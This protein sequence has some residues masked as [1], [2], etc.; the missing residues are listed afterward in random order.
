[1]FILTKDGSNTLLNKEFNAHYHSLHGALEETKHVFIRSGLD[2]YLTKFSSLTDVA[3]FE[4]GFG[5]G[6]NAL[7]SC[8][9]ALEHK[10]HLNYTAI[11]KAPLI[12]F[13]SDGFI[14][15]MDDLRL[16][17]QIFKDIHFAAWGD[18]IAINPYFNIHKKHADIFNYEENEI[19]DI[20]FY[21]AFA[22]SVQPELWTTELMRR[23]HHSIKPNGLLITYCAQ[24]QFKRNLKDAGFIVESIPGPSGKREIT[25]GLKR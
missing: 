15:P 25:R 24:G 16:H 5:T 4:M 17:K 10:I 2:Y 8:I 20:I 18:S 21:D 19:N 13:D 23:L 11:E 7:M 1:M 6:L 12:N 9:Y 22:P 3:L 14:G